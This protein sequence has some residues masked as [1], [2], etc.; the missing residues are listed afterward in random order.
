MSDKLIIATG[1]SRY[2]THWKSE[3]MTWDSLVERL[4]QV[5]RTQET[6]AEYKKME[7]LKKGEVKDVGGFVGGYIPEEGRRVKGAFKERYLLTLDADSPTDDFQL[8]LDITLGGY[9]YCLYS[10]HS[11]AD[12]DP[13]YR[14]IVP[15]DRPMSVDEFEAVSRRI[16]GDIGIESFDTS[17]HEAERLMYWPSCPRDAKYVFRHNKG[18][19]LPVDTVLAQ[20]RDWHDTS[21][22]PTSDKDEAVRKR[23]AAKQGD[24]LTKPGLI[25][26]FNRCYTISAAI[27]KFLPDIYE[28][29]DKP[30]RYTYTP[31][32]SVGGLVIYDN[33]TF[34]Y[35]HHGTDPIMGR[36]VNAFDL[37]RLHKFGQLDADCDRDTKVNEL[38]SMKAMKDF[39]IADGEA[40]VLL[41][42]E[43]AQDIDWDGGVAEEDDSEWRKKLSRDK[44]GVARSTATNCKLILKHDPLLKGKFGLDEFAHRLVRLGPLPWPTGQDESKF[45]TDNDDAC[46]RNY[47]TD[48]YG[49]TGRGIIDD[50][51]QEMMTVNKFHP[52]RD[53]LTTLKWDGVERVSRLFVEC[54]GAADTPYVRAVTRK[55]LV[56]A[57]AR[58]MRPGVKFDT[59]IVLYG[60]QGMGK[61]V[62]LSKLGKS[63][64]NDSLA[65]VQSKDALEQIQGSWIV[66][67]AEL[68]PTFK[69][70]NEIVK[71]FLSR[72]TD[73]FR[74]PYGR[75]TEEYPRQCVFAGS[76]NDLLFLKDRTGNRRFWPITAGAIEPVKRSWD[77]TDEDIDQIWAEAFELWANCEPL[78]LPPELEKDALEAQQAHTEG[79]ELVGLIEEYLAT[80]LPDDW[81]KKELWERQEY[82]K[83][84]GANKLDES[85]IGS[86]PRDK[87]CALEIWC[88]LLYGDRKNLT[89]AKAREIIS[90]LQSLGTW[91]P[92]N[93]STGK[94]RF[95]T[96]YGIQKAFV[97][98]ST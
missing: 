93:T 37:V 11:H 79:T 10:T 12:K 64:F 28:P 91:V 17:T 49:I 71:S 48:V 68:A 3:K 2:D 77:M 6:V 41:D 36:L 88:E 65:D 8:G 16:A 29:C 72:S 15:T 66:E 38:P 39:V 85:K 56:A 58:V 5:Q 45:W 69:K 84:Y 33:D 40:P 35:S 62:I 97:P 80:P 23:L 25:G 96:M 90:I 54:L 76:T 26:A 92:Y 70:D 7:K 51:L 87:V 52:V 47:F 43:R 63:W 57:V 59:A 50:A 94:M 61:S 53:Y 89:N 75:R 4:S 67:L 98:K 55:W 24:P 13:R 46:L 34:A 22:W 19:L 83:E 60:P 78:V 20:Y 21:L 1:T 14:V 31:G 9:E 27:E 86:N 81:E 82:L 42:S 30:G 95:G 73:R 32:T 74:A 18:E 44:N